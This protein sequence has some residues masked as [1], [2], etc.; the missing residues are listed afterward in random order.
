ME[1]R[2]LRSMSGLLLLL[3]LRVAFEDA[4]YVSMNQAGFCV[5]RVG[6]CLS[7]GPK[8]LSAPIAAVKARRWYILP[9]PG[10]P[11]ST[12]FASTLDMMG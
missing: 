3:Y 12:T 5:V 11:S 6:E 7:R 2:K 4:K 9:T 1:V 10:R 8:I